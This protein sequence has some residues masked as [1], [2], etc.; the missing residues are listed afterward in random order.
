MDFDGSLRAA[1]RTIAEIRIQLET[2]GKVKLLEELEMHLGIVTD[3]VTVS[4]MRAMKRWSD[5]QQPEL[6]EGR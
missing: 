3:T 2:E 5:N 6:K 4:K 1:F